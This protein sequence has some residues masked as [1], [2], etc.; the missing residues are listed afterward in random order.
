MAG[1]A[2]ATAGTGAYE[3]SR[4]HPSSSNAGPA[5]NTAGPH[6]SDMMNK[7]DPRV[8]SD[9]SKQQ[10]APSAATG[11]SSMGQEPLTQGT[12]HTGYE[13]PYNRSAVDPRLNK[14]SGS[15]TTNT[16]GDHHYGRDAGVAGAGGLAAYEA[17]KHHHKKEDATIASDPSRN[18]ANQPSATSHHHYGRDAGLA[19]AGGTAAYEA[20]KHH[21]NREH[22]GRTSDVSGT[23]AG[24]GYNQPTESDRHH[25]VGRDTALTGAGGA[26]A[27]EAEK[28]HRNKEHPGQTSD[29]SG[30]TAGSGYNQPTETGHHHNVGRDTAL[31]GAG[32]ATAYEAEKHHHR[33]EDTRQSGVTGA[34]NTRQGGP[35]H[36]DNNRQTDADYADRDRT[37]Y[38]RDTALAGG[39]GAVGGHELSKKETEKAEKQ[40]AKEEAKHEKTL[41]K[42]QKQHAKEEAKHE[43]ALEKEEKHDGKKHGGLFGFLHRDKADDEL[44]EEEA[45]R[46]GNSSHRGEEAAGVGAVG[47]GA[48]VAEHE[49]HGHDRNRS[50]LKTAQSEASLTFSRLHKDP[51]ASMQ[52]TAGSGVGKDGMVT[53]PRTGLPMDTSLGTGAG[54]TDGA[55]IP[56]YQGQGATS[57]G[58]S[59]ASGYD[60]AHTGGTGNYE[61]RSDPRTGQAANT[62][63]GSGQGGIGSI[64]GSTGPGSAY[65]T[66]G[67]SGTSNY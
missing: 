53:E 3:A 50:V 12:G 40:Q 43:K 48:A 35:L 31:A 34:G 23:T 13:N 15:V 44:K 9:L 41:E 25:N 36:N 18:T 16:S 28:H 61:N 63:A 20:E 29:T 65:G 56:G 11:T 51:P 22:P 55:P 58:M 32:G 37:H 62:M 4:D 7:M 33:N 38:G 45:G 66:H 17:E 26:T 59:G 2:V 5:P 42:E 19:G 1:G 30:T 54:G 24:S 46:K 49:H 57:G 14:T 60:T 64:Q 47:A 10:G 52:N 67:T 27:Y 8:D 39:A 6:K 21:Q